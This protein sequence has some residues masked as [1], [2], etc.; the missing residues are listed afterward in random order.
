MPPRNAANAL[1][2]G[3]APAQSARSNVPPYHPA[4]EGEAYWSAGDFAA[5]GKC[6]KEALGSIS[7]E[8]PAV[9]QRLQRIACE[10]F[11]EL[12]D[13]WEAAILADQG[14]EIGDPHSSERAATHLAY[15][16]AAS[17]LGLLLLAREE[18]AKAAKV[19]R[20]FES[21][22]VFD[23][24]HHTVSAAVASRLAVFEDGTGLCRETAILSRSLG[25]EA[26]KWKLTVDHDLSSAGGR[27]RPV[28]HGFLDRPR[29]AKVREVATYRCFNYFTKKKLQNVISVREIDRTP[30]REGDM[31]GGSYH[32][33]H[34]SMLLTP[35]LPSILDGS[36]VETLRRERLVVVDNAIG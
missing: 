24:K 10:C 35:S 4:V 7:N 9:L 32:C 22:A 30:Q 20:R 33:I 19:R 27:E 12:E 1:R 28:R 2:E 36:A 29:D 25:D 26:A 3:E 11:L 23:A 16:S 34:P 8:Q 17:G 21:L 31:G 6:L 5:A 15:A 13:W 14:L 18:L